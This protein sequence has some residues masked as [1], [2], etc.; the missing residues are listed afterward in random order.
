MI[1]KFA[2]LPILLQNDQI[3][4][5]FT[6]CKGYADAEDPELPCFCNP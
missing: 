3:G 6:S 1:R 4:L 2:E 5:D